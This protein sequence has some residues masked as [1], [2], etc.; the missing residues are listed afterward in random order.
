MYCLRSGTITNL[1]Q[2]NK[3]WI[4]VAI[5][6]VDAKWTKYK[7]NNLIKSRK[8]N[9]KIITWL[10]KKNARKEKKGEEAN[11]KQMVNL[12]SNILVTILNVNGWKISIK[13]KYCYTEFKKQW[14]TYCL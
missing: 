8:W 13:G 9:D 2:I 5:S 12:N 4:Y 10:I 3:S 14:N 6:R 11:G 1:R 7:S